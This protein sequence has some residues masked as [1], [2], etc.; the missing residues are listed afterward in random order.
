MDYI[1]L[2]LAVIL[3]ALNFAATKAYQNRKGVSI[4]NGLVFNI[5]IGIFTAAAFFIARGF[6]CE[7][8]LYSVLMASAMGIL[9]A[10]YTLIGFKIMETK[11]VA[12]YT[13][14]LMTGG[15]VV[16]YIWGIIFLGEPL[17]VLRTFGLLVIISAVYITNTDG[18][19]TDPKQL[20]LCIAVFFLNGFVSVVS[21]EHQIHTGAVS[22]ADFV[23]LSSLAKAVCCFAA[24][25]FVPKERGTKGSSPMA[26]ILIFACA[27]LGGVSYLFQLMGAKNLPATVLYP[28]ITGGCII[29]T[30]I[31]GRIFF[32]EKMSKRLIGGIA[33]CFAGTCM[34]L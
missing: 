26:Y 4:G 32:G 31:A 21:K 5:W 22:S 18:E 8:N 28:I 13:V 2:I 33:L 17:S 24:Y 12:L 29:F 9:G 15:M 16:P 11:K 23:V 10:V 6:H 30:A 14:F 25:L 27:I 20:I 1:L 3:L 34:F 19:K 7:I